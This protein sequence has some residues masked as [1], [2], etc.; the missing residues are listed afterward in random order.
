[1]LLISRVPGNMCACL[2]GRR[3]YLSFC[4]TGTRKQAYDLAA[5]A[6]EDGSFFVWNTQYT[7]QRNSAPQT[8]CL[9]CFPRS[10]VLLSSNV[11]SITSRCCCTAAVSSTPSKSPE[12][13]LS[14][15]VAI[16]V[17]LRFAKLGLES[18]QTL[19]E[20]RIKS[21]PLLFTREPRIKTTC[22]ACFRAA[23]KTH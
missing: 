20:E 19:L 21:S 5:D 4:L 6:P 15:D 22:D 23:S 8:C 9:H 7:S 18:R 11:G 13:P 16:A 12:D 3:V 10:F 14:F 1:M 2:M 17:V